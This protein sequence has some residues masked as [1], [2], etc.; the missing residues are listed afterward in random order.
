[1]EDTKEK[2]EKIFRKCSVEK[3]SALLTIAK[4]KKSAMT[5]TT[6]SG[7]LDQRGKQLGAIISSLTRT[8]IDDKPLLVPVGRTE[9]G[10]LWRLNQDVAP[11]NIVKELVVQ[12]LEE[13]K[14]YHIE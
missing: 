11:K 9:E 13:N 6:I 10:V 4:N 5:T 8:K 7:S 1:M 3:L 14:E 2:L 12:I